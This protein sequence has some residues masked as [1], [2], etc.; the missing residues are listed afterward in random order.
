MKSLKD[1]SITRRELGRWPLVIAL[2]VLVLVP[3]SPLWP[4][5]FL[6]KMHLVGYAICHQMPEHSYH[7]GGRQLPLCARC[8]GIYLGALGGLLT[9]FAL[10]K[11][12]AARLPPLKLLAILM[13][14]IALFAI[15]GLNS[16]LAFF[17]DAPHLYEPRVLVGV[18]LIIILIVEMSAPFLFY[19]LAL[20]SI[21]GI[22]I[23]VTIIN[24][25]ILV[26]AI[27]REASAAALSDAI[28]PTLGA[29]LLTFL[30]IGAM[31][32][33]HTLAGWALPSG[34]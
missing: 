11:G 26:I 30:E 3:L 9:L 13:G 25:L 6:E 20:A 10:G 27:R 21:L 22:I 2:T 23:L 5:P 33:L 34:P 18:T 7:L 16:Y 15:D 4:V 28:L 12:R 32:L 17:P 1:H 14:F 31:D 8:T 29:V 24:L 19:P